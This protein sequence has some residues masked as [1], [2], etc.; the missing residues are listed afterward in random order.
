MK[1]IINMSDVSI[2]MV[3]NY[4][5]QNSVADLLAN[6]VLGLKKNWVDLVAPPACTRDAL[7]K[8]CMGTTGLL[9]PVEL[10]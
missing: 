7:W 2:V 5:E 10:P 8:D 3:H 6:V 9:S 4:R 1:I